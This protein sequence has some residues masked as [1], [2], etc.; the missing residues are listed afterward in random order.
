MLTFSCDG[1]TVIT[2]ASWKDNV[3]EAQPISAAFTTLCADR[4]ISGTEAR[5]WVEAHPAAL[6]TLFDGRLAENGSHIAVIDTGVS[7]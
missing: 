2:R 6:P 1:K 4:E 7:Q 5:R 3:V